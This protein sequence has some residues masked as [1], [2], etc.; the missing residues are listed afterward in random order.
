METISKMFTLNFGDVG[1]ALV[2]AVLTGLALP[3]LAVVQT[4]GF[5][6][7]TTD[8]S[9]LLNLAING[10]ILGA[11]SYLVKQFFSDKEGKF[12]GVVG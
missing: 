3:V 4:P 8:W 7:F 5:D 12:A 10:A 2:M 11:S 6:V 9:V 1:K